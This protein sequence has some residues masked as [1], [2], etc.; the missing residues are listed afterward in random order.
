MA[1]RSWSDED[2]RRAVADSLSWSQAARA[3]GLKTNGGGSSKRMQST[4]ATLGLDTSHFLAGGWNKGTGNGRDPVK[5]RAGKQRWYESNRQVYRAANRRR[6]VEKRR[7]IARLKSVPCTDCGGKFPYFVMDFDH[8][9]GEEKLGNVSSMVVV[10]SWKRLL[11]E[12]AKCDVVCANCHRIRT[13]RRGGW[14]EH[15]LL[16]SGWDIGVPAG[17]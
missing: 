2:L 9:D 1:I 5:A 11:A 7:E 6:Y 3:L 17:P 4:A 8:R 14:S 13:A 16:D 10:W 15:D 12:I